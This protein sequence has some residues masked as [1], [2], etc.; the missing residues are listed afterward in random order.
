M[1][2]STLAFVV[3]AAS[4]EEALSKMLSLGEAESLEAGEPLENL[5]ATMV[6]QILNAEAISRGLT[7]T[8]LVNDLLGRAT[9]DAPEHTDT[10]VPCLEKYKQM[11]DFAATPEPSGSSGRAKRLNRNEPHALQFCVQKHDASWLHYDFRLELNG[12]LKS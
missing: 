5:R 11:R 6:E 12:T 3:L 1:D 2:D 8:Q 9:D 4:D 7:R 10:S